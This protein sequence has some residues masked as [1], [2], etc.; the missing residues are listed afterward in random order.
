MA[1]RKL[2]KQQQQAVLA[3][4]CAGSTD[5]E[6]LEVLNTEH[7]VSISYQALT[8][9][10]LKWADQIDEAEAQALETAKR[11]GW[12]R[13]S[14]RVAAICR[15]LDKLDKCLDDEALSRW[16]NLGREMREWMNE[17]REELGQQSPR[18]HEHGGSVE[19]TFREVP[20]RDGD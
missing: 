10:R 11:Q 7:G 19:I 18:Q 13:R 4:M 3:L 16:R 2:T 12:G 5:T 17:L 15:K 9:Y 1:A 14:Y 6:V 8:H 20:A